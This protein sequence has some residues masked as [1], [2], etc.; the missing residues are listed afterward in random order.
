MIARWSL[1][2]LLGYL[3]TWSATLRYMEANASDP[4]VPLDRDIANIWGNREI[5]RP[6]LWPLELRV[7]Q[8]AP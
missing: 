5:K 4:L 1:E 7:G 6:V 8:S 3:R 2:E